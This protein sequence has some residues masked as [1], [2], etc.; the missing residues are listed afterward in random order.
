MKLNNLKLPIEYPV[1]VALQIYLKR[2]FIFFIVVFANFF[3]L[4][5]FLYAK[6]F[7][8]ILVILICYVFVHISIRALRVRR[9]ISNPDLVIEELENLIEQGSY[10]AA[11]KLLT[12]YMNLLPRYPDPIFA[13]FKSRL[14][15]MTNGNPK[16]AEIAFVEALKL[17]KFLEN[18]WQKISLLDKSSYFTTVTRERYMLLREIGRGGLSIVFEGKDILLE[19]KVAIKMLPCVM[20]TNVEEIRKRILREAGIV[21]MLKHPNITEVYDLFID[22][23]KRILFIIFEYVE[24]LSLENLI[25]REGKLNVIK[26]LEILKGICEGMSYA[27]SKN[28]IHLDLKPSNVLITS[29][30]MVKIIDFGLAEIL[31]RQTLNLAHKITGSLAYMSPEQHLGEVDFRSDIYSLGV[32]FYEMVTGEVPFKGP[33]FLLQKEKMAYIKPTKIISDLP[34]EIDEFIDKCLHNEKTSRFSSMNEILDIILELTTKFRD[35]TK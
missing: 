24:G 7:I 22:E 25:K 30:Q 11:D 4:I 23:I 10:V 21:N 2:F 5:L 33:N 32:M 20:G 6:L 13:I 19:R 9:V 12:N 18:E 16:S 8:L 31:N 34:P 28:V 3:I 17:K 14:Y 1:R 26:S 35:R 15:S 29:Q 27:H